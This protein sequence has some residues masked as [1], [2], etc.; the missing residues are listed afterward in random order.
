MPTCEQFYGLIVKEHPF[1]SSIIM[2]EVR[3]RGEVAVLTIYE[4]FNYTS[5]L[6]HDSIERGSISV[7][8][9]LLALPS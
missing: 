8:S 9:K 3:F 5:R 4:D 2:S 6:L 7:S 1:Y